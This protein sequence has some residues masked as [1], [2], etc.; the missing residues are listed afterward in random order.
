[1]SK[2]KTK[3][4]KRR[5][6][7]D[8]AAERERLAQQFF[9]ER[10]R[11]YRIAAVVLPIV[12]LAAAIGIYLA[13]DDKQLAGLTGM[14][15]LAIWLPLVIGSIGSQVTPRDRT[16]AGAIDFGSERRR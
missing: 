10:R 13:T 5:E 7:R 8:E 11:K 9:E 14:V 2:K 6:E 12:A 3:R 16:R 1:M 15:G 4:D